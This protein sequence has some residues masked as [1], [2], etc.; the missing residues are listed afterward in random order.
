MLL[1]PKK[2]KDFGNVHESASWKK[3]IEGNLLINKGFSMVKIKD[4]DFF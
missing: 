1:L 4:L 2:K 3:K